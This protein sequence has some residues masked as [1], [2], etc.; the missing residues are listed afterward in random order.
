MPSDTEKQQRETPAS[1]ARRP[2][3]PGRPA[4]AHAPVPEEHEGATENQ[5]SDVT[6]P[7]G[8]AYDDEP[9]QG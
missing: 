1:D 4:P 3:A 6:P 5:V 2:L 8:P 7:A 9:K